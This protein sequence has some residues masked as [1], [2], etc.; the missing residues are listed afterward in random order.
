M[1]VQHNRQNVAQLGHIVQDAFAQFGVRLDVIV[2]FGGEFARFAE[3]LV[4]DADLADIVQQATQVDG[5]QFVG[6]AVEL[7]ASVTAMRATRSL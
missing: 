4:L 5:V 6:R 7:A 3:H 2:L 1:V